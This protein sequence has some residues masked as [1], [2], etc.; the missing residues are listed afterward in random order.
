ML[1]VSIYR[2]LLRLYPALHRERFGEEMVAVFGKMQAE[3]ATKNMLD[4]GMF[5]ARETT[6]VVGGEVLQDPAT[7]ETGL[8]AGQNLVQWADCQGR[9]RSPGGGPVAH[10]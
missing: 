7:G 4:R 5:L 6:G 1:S 10:N 8:R 9:A 3:T 2:S